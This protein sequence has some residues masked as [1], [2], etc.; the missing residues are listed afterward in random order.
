[1]MHPEYEEKI[2]FVMDQGLLCYK[3]IPFGLRN[4]GA[5]Y[6]RMM[7][8]VFAAQ[9]G[10]NVEAYVDDMLVKSMTEK[11]H[12]ENLGET[13]KTM[14][15]VGMKL[16]PKKSFFGLAGGKFLDFVVTKKG[17][18][19]HPSKSKGIL[20]MAT[21]KNLKELQSLT[22]RLAVLNRFIIKY[23]EVCLPFFKAM[24]RSNK[25]EWTDD[26]QAAFDRIKQYL[27]DLSCL[28]RLRVG[29]TL[30]LYVVSG[31]QAVSAALVREEG[32]EQRPIYFVSHVL[33]DVETRYPPL[34]KMV[35]ALVVA[36]RK[37]R[38]YF[39]VHPIKVLT[40]KTCLACRL[41]LANDSSGCNI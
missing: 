4:T 39:Q 15:R 38:P 40:S 13:F 5:T 22:G 25:F 10:C 8:T 23:R 30:I 19:I 6:Q 1:M 36:A 28:T 2:T 7:N 21:P 24:N 37:L 29:K 26:C 18:E 11:G 35:F 41:L 20:D 14:R 31:D 9:I 27:D 16:N 12:I 17:I 34:E 32:R 33:R 3:V